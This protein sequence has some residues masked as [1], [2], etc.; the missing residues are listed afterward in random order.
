MTKTENREEEGPSILSYMAVV[1]G[2]GESEVNK[3]NKAWPWMCD[4]RDLFLL[5]GAIVL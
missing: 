2:D 1:L 5:L 3:V 4:S